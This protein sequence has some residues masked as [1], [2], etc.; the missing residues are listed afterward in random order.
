MTSGRII[1]EPDPHKCRQPD[2]K[3]P[4]TIWRCDCERN[5]IRGKDDTWIAVSALEVSS[6]MFFQRLGESIR[7]EARRKRD[8]G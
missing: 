4:G 6:F 7:E 3:P 2:G 8:E 5:W 1:F